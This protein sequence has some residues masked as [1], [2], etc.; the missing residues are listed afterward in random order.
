MAYLSRAKWFEYGEKSNKF[1]LNLIRSRQNQKLIDKIRNNEK[2]FVGPVQV[3]KGIT[4]FSEIFTPN[5][6]GVSNL[7]VIWR[8]LASSQ[9]INPEKFG[10]LCEKTLEQYMSCAEWYDIP[11]SLHRVLV[12]EEGAESK[13]KIARRFHKS[14]T[15]KT[16][17]EDTM[18]DLFH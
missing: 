7:D 3:S 12:H 16:S 1:F 8:T 17:Q 18:L 5:N 13:T 11:P 4:E 15:W 9:P 10:E 6:A 2:E 14:H